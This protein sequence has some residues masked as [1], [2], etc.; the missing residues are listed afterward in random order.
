VVAVTPLMTVVTTPW[1]AESVDEVIILV[2]VATPLTV[3][4]SVLTRD[5][6]SLALTKRAVVVA[7]VPLT[8]EE[9]VKELVEVETVRVWDVDEATRVVRSVEVATPFM[10][11]VRNVPLVERAF[12]VIRDD[13]AVIPLMTEVRT[14]PVACW[15]KDVMIDASDEE[16]PFTIVWKRLADEEAVSEVMILVVPTEPPMF[17]VRVFPEDERVF[18]VERLVVVRLVVVALVAVR[19][20]KVPVSAV[21]SDEKKEVEVP[22]V[23]RASVA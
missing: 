4:V 18:E 7:T 6:R 5:V 14:L 20:V 8:I 22:E 3:E 21:R 17:E 15:V 1:L 9:S 11:V 10:V 12:E 23:R 19:L 16:T 2:E 13:V